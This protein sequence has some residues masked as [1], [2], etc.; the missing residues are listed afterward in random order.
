MEQTKKVAEFI[1]SLKRYRGGAGLYK[2]TP[3]LGIPCKENESQGETEFVVVAGI[4]T[5]CDGPETS[6]FPAKADGEITSWNELE[7]SFQGE[8]DHGKA[9]AKAGYTMKGK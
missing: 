2:L 5:P 6:I 9:L 7:G 3:P 8:I 1:R 4:V